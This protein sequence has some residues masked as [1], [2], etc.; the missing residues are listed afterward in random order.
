MVIKLL[1]PLAL[2]GLLQTP[3]APPAATAPATTTPQAVTPQVATPPSAKPPSATPP[4]ATP[5][6]ETEFGTVLALIDRMQRV[7]DGAAKDE[8]GKVSIG[9]ADIDEMRSELA[10][11]RTILDARNR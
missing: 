10:Q 4:T 5:K 1:L 6:A 8:L 9:R 3:T 2:A 11:I 7:L